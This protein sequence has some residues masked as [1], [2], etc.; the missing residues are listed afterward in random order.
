MKISLYLPTG[1]GHEFAE[2]DP[3]D[4]F[5][6]II[7]LAHAADESGYET[8]WAPDHF[9]TLPPAPA[10]TFEVW[11]TLAALARE[12]R[13]VRIG[14]MVTGVSYRSPALQAK[15]ASTLDVLSQ[16]RFTF[17][18]GA[19]WYEAEYVSYG[20]EFPGVRER[21]ARLR[22][23]VQIIRS[24]WTEPETTF[25][26]EYYQ[27]HGAINE[28]KGVQS[29]HVPMMIAGSGEK[30]TLR[31]VAEFGDA[32]NIQTS[33]DE[34][35]R[36][37]AILRAHCEDVERPSE[38]ITRTSTGL[39]IIA[40]SD[41]EA[42]AAVPPWA[43]QVFPDDVASYGL[44]GTVDTIR[45]RLAAYEDAGVQELLVGFLDARDPNTVRRFASE[46]LYPTADGAHEFRR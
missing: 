3:V 15:M 35:R 43:P 2:H 20:Y 42:R 21:L 25:E 5:D 36:K 14:Q 4:A 7:E 23:A 34:F 12:T 33:P 6:T 27:V 28:P 30:V 10:P 9:V 37:D 29:P 16:G 46:F 41:E 31:T 22:E 45:K 1:F 8:V 11:T 32:C 26:G 24:M 39:C 18:I 38:E 13:R 44:I 19:G 17:G 40:D